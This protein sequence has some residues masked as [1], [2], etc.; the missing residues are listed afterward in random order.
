MTKNKK[1]Y[2]IEETD[3]SWLVKD[4]TDR[5]DLSDEVRPF[6]VR[7]IPEFL[8]IKKINYEYRTSQ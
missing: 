7:P 1:R 8:I 6:R 5:A 2:K 4:E 3:P